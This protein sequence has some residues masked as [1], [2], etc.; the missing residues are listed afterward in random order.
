MK[1]NEVVLEIF[2]ILIL[3][4]YMQESERPD[5]RVNIRVIEVHL[6]GVRSSS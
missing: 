3:F 5:F 4:Y 2:Q 6:P 1:I